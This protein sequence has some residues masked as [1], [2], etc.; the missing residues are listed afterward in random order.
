MEN[1][2]IW[3]H[4][5]RCL[6]GYMP[7]VSHHYSEL[8]G[9]ITKGN[10]K[11]PMRE[12]RQKRTERPPGETWQA[13]ATLLPSTYQAE[14][15]RRLLSPSR[16]VCA[17]VDLKTWSYWALKPHLEKSKL[18]CGIGISQRNAPR[19]TNQVL[20]KTKPLAEKLPGQKAL[21]PIP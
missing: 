9:L 11:A 15:L 2:C 21:E 1:I 7:P 19:D 14:R 13:Q 6:A 4:R 8:A 10:G 16:S 12:T 20:E 17:V 5:N 18:E 3:N